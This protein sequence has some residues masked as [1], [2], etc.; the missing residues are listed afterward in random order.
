MTI[1]AEKIR[2]KIQFIRETVRRLEEI[3]GRGREAFLADPILQGAAE[4]S[5]QVGIEAMLDTASHIIAREGFAISKTYREAMDTLVREGILPA[6]HG[7]R[8]RSMATFRNRVV[9][10]YDRIDPAEVYSILEGHLGDFETFL[11]AIIRRYLSSDEKED[12]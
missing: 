7:E 1:D 4:R 8:F 12:S 5:L 2:T 9:H 11:G 3:R 6:S 10:L